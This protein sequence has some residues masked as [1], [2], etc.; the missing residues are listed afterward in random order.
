M[1][2]RTV[3]AINAEIRQTVTRLG[4]LRLERQAAQRADL[5]AKLRRIVRPQDP[6]PSQPA[7]PA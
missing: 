7:V 4:E 2:A 5:R 3:K 1:P 6:K